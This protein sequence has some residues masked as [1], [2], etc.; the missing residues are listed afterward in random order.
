[1]RWQELSFFAPNLNAKLCVSFPSMANIAALVIVF[2][3]INKMRQSSIPMHEAVSHAY[4]ITVDTAS[5]K[6][7][8]AKQFMVGRFGDWASHG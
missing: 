1:M 3:A 4:R 7:R 6:S 8:D 2:H 5:K